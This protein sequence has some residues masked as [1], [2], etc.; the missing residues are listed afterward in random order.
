ML[1]CFSI[2][3]AL[4]AVILIYFRIANRYNIIDKPNERSSHSRI[5]VRGGGIVF[6]LAAMIWFFVFGFQ[7][8]WA[9]TGLMLIAG[10]SFL[11]DI[12]P[13]PGKLR[14]II[15]LIAVSM[16]FY[17][18]NIFELP[19]YFILLA[20]LF[21][22]GWINAFNF[23]DG[24]NAIT[25]FYALVALL[26]LMY[27]N[28]N[29][30][31]FNLDLQLIIAISVMVFSFFNA[32]RQAVTF[33][34]DV[35]SI[36]LAFLLSW[37]VIAL[38]L[39]TRNY[40]YILIFVV[41]GIDSVFTILYRLQKGENIFKAHRLH[42]YQLLSNELNWPHVWVAVV[43]SIAQAGINILVICLIRN[44]LM[45]IAILIILIL[46]FSATYLVARYFAHRQTKN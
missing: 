34:G 7:E 17:Q 6:P 19:W 21:T 16:L 22:T 36:S 10:I 28:Y 20:Y 14:I 4:I 44:G 9:I 13:L 2:S 23:M 39:Q 31:F 46:A 41:Y 25:P 27:L 43:Y 11:D 18:L 35:G 1:T 29:S 30:T 38:M 26:T 15:H 32:R 37:M 33:A 8:A 5:T 3:L 24:V 40:E 45:S 42:L 12:S